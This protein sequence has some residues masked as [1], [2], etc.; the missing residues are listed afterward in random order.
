MLNA[1][2]GSMLT[3]VL[4]D[5]CAQLAFTKLISRSGWR[6]ARAQS[7]CVSV[8][9]KRLTRTGEYQL[10]RV[11]KRDQSHGWRGRRDQRLRP[12]CDRESSRGDHTA[13]ARTRQPNWPCSVSV[14]QGLPPV[15]ASLSRTIEDGKVDDRHGESKR[16][17]V[18]QDSSDESD[19]YAL[20][21]MLSK[22]PRPRAPSC[23]SSRSSRVPPSTT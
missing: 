9:M 4:G 7:Q 17:L 16:Q 23:T 13:S 2:I 5:V 11:K 10:A 12:L 1:L 6:T 3:T 20:R 15:S 8:G 18:D 22:M 21:R 19:L 14:S